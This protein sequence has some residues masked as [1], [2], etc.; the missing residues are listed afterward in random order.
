MEGLSLYVCLSTYYVVRKR[1]DTQCG[2]ILLLGHYYHEA[3]SDYFH[4]KL[5]FNWNPKS[6][7]CGIFLFS[8]YFLNCVQ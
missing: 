8:L 5:L 6:N 3:S 1:E 4:A 7:N 2:L